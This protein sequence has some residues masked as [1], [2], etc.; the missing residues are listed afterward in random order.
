MSYLYLIYIYTNVYCEEMPLRRYVAASKR[1]QARQ[2]LHRP[3]QL[4][5]AAHGEHR[6]GRATELGCRRGGR[7]RRRGQV[8]RWLHGAGHG[9]WRG[10]GPAGQAEGAQR[11]ACEQPAGAAPHGT[12][13]VMSRALGVSCT[14]LEWATC[15]GPRVKGL[16]CKVATEVQREVRQTAF[17]NGF[18]WSSCLP[19]A[20]S[21]KRLAASRSSEEGVS[22]W[23]VLAKPGSKLLGLIWCRERAPESEWSRKASRCFSKML[24]LLWALSCAPAHSI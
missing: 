13:W 3:L 1:I 8:D 5:P 21:V 10:R 15:V 7:H 19:S 24:W 22:T 23:N 9:P 2:L 18:S 14:S 11:Q 4:M 16:V 17:S 12:L 20:A 6:D